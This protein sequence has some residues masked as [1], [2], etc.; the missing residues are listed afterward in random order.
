MTP[1]ERSEFE[2]AIRAAGS[3]HH[4]SKIL[5]F[6]DSILAHILHAGSRFCSV[7]GNF[8]YN[9]TAAPI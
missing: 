9:L 3:I 4:E 7:A 8:C 2:H 1:C 6:G 5:A